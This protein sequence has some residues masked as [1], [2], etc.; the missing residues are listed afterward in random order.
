MRLVVVNIISVQLNKKEQKQNGWKERK[1]RYA[2]RTI[3][4]GNAKEAYCY[5]TFKVLLRFIGKLSSSGFLPEISTQTQ[6]PKCE[7][8]YFF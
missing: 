7:N 3:N 4:H 2:N 6:K 8:N 1:S 5:E